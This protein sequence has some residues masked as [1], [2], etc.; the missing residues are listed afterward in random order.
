MWML[1]TGPEP[2]SSI[3]PP[4]CSSFRPGTPARSRREALRQHPLLRPGQL[5]EVAR[6]L[7]GR[8]PDPRELARELTRRG[9]LTPFQV[10]RLF[11]GRAAE[12]VAQ[13]LATGGRLVYVGA[14]T[15]GRLGTLDAVE[16]VPTFGIPPSRVVP[17]MAGGPQA[18]TRSVEGAEDNVRDAEQRLRRVAAGPAFQ[19]PYGY[20]A[21]SMSFSD[22]NSVIGSIQPGDDVDLIASYTGGES[23]SDTKLKQTQYAMNDVRV[24]GVGG[25]PPAPAAPATSARP[26]G[27]SP[28]AQNANGGSLLLLVRYQQALLIQHLKDFGGSWTT[29]A[30]L[31]SSKEADI[32]HFRTTPIAGR[33]FFTKADNHFDFKLPY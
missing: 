11:Q 15:S 7:Q 17:V 22:V 13:R 1:P 5:D 28:T 31:R 18:L 3:S 23:P 33:W 14:G 32:P 30:V 21:I 9:W 19:I 12:L 25:P 26:G 27:S 16:C 29:S 20:V 8:F 24:I 4:R 6:D 2:A 10:N